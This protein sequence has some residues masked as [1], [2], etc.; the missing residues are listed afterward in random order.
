[1]INQSGDP[2]K[3]NVDPTD[4]QGGRTAGWHMPRRNRTEYRSVLKQ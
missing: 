2:G 1:M 4:Y 3:H